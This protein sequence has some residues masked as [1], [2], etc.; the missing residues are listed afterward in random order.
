[1]SDSPNIQLIQLIILDLACAQSEI[2]T[3]SST[4]SQTMSN[5]GALKQ[6]GKNKV[7]IGVG[8]GV[9]CGVIA[10]LSLVLVIILANRRKKIQPQIE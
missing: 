7:K 4:V 5:N 3:N 8:V 1:M 2:Q 6:G 9:G 10:I